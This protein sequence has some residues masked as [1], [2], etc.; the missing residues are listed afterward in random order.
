MLALKKDDLESRVVEALPWLIYNF[1]DMDWSE[2]I[3]RA[4]LDDAQNRLGF[5]LN[6]AHSLAKRSGDKDKKDLFKR[7]LGVLKKSRLLSE[8]SFRRVSLTEAEKKWVKK[9][10]PKEARHWRILTNLIA[11]HLIF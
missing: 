6:I 7:L 4:K 1:P 10:R 2:I 9:N 3:K 8:D 11:E 5:L